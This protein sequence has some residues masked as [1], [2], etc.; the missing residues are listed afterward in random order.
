MD[1]DNVL[2]KMKSM[3][4][5]RFDPAIVSALIAAVAAGDVAPPTLSASEPVRRQ[6]V[7]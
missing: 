4:G 6:E 5:H 2:T 3:A 1:L 7:S